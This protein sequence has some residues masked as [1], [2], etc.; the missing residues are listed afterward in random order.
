MNKAE[1]IECHLL[2]HTAC[3]SGNFF[4]YFI[5]LHDEFLT[6]DCYG[7]DKRIDKFWG[8]KADETLHL[9]V[10]RHNLW[11]GAVGT[12]RNTTHDNQDKM[13]WKEHVIFSAITAANHPHER[14]SAT[15]TKICCKPNLL[16]NVKEG[17]KEGAIQQ[18]LETVQPKCLY[19]PDV[20]SAEHFDIFL[21]RARRLRPYKDKN[22]EPET[23]QDTGVEMNKKF[24]ID[25]L[26][27]QREK[28]DELKTMLDV[29]VIDAGKL[30]FDVDEDEYALLLKKIGGEP[31][32]NW[33][34]VIK[35]YTKLVYKI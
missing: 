25:Q 14:N 1:D 26:E 5:S 24:L 3:L 2:M 16:H 35:D 17:W 30:L 32:A 10:E 31:L 23:F 6:A 33:K 7:I 9:A 12:S 22:G 27:G 15:F 20:S 21:E 11:K 19:L 28:M 13:S 18:L 34:Q 8:Q 4:L 29:H